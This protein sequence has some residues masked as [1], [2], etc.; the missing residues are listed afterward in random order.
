MDDIKPNFLPPQKYFCFENNNNKKN[1]RNN[2]NNNK[3]NYKTIKITRVAGST[4]ING[5]HEGQFFA[6]P[7][8]FLLWIQ[9]NNN[10]NN[11]N[12]NDNKT[13]AMAMA[14][15]MAMAIAK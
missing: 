8:I 14:M 4:Q 1:K 5:Q 3:S 6:A 9:Y 12:E 2:D 10:N 15:A 11:N 7:Q 13:T